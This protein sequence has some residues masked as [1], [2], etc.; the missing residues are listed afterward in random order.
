MKT[1]SISASF[2]LLLVC[3]TSVA[4]AQQYTQYGLYGSSSALGACEAGCRS[5]QM[6]P[7]QYVPAARRSVQS[8]YE[9][10]VNNGWR[11]QNLLGA[12]HFNP[13]SNE[14]TEAGKLKVKW[15]LSQ[16]P[17]HRRSIF[18]ER[19]PDQSR[20]DARVASINGWAS[21]MS[22]SVGIVDINDTHIVAEGH[23]A[24]AVDHIFV[25]FQTNQ[26]APVLPAAGSTSSSSGSTN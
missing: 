9:V 25:G 5:N 18:V 22:P 21:T 8:A 7:S 17:Q 10:M 2:V 15:I 23:P 11:R 6:W 13:D 1:L 16:A 14:L 19:G 12:Y 3:S 4:S 26:P 20:T 24:G